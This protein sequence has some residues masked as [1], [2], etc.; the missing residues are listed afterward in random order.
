[1]LNAT[2]A[3]KTTTIAASSGADVVKPSRFRPVAF[4]VVILTVGGPVAACGGPEE[5]PGAD[6][7]EADS[8]TDEAIDV[9]TTPLVELTEEPGSPVEIDEPLLGRRRLSL[10]RSLGGE[11]SFGQIT[12]IRQLDSLLFVT[13]YRLP[14]HLKVME[15]GSGRVIGGYGRAGEGPGEFR[16]ATAVFVRSRDPPT[17][18][19][20]DYR[21]RRVSYVRFAGPDPRPELVDE[22]SL[23]YDEIGL[24][25]LAPYD[26]RFVAGGL[27]AD[28]SLAV[29]GRNGRIQERLV[30]EPPFG[31]EDIG[32]SRGFAALMNNVHFA[33]DG[34]GRVALAYEEESVVDLVDPDSRS[35][36]RVLGP[37]PVE[38]RYDVRD[39]RLHTGDENERAFR[40]VAA[41]DRLVFAG[42]LGGRVQDMPYGDRPHRVLVF[43]WRGRYLAELDL[44]RGITALGVSRDGARLWAGYQDPHP[45]IGEWTVPAPIRRAADAGGDAAGVDVR[46]DLSDAEAC[47]DRDR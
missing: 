15:M 17:V 4:A 14:P 35:Y 42:F 28:F 6:E 22:V 40:F 38:T 18:G 21:N 2:P 41:T 23:V 31:P 43:D 33:S 26:G 1:M 11:E 37:E 7:S 27:F 45:R 44:G 9:S 19:V 25:G 29:V 39:G 30:T 36:R 5:H 13:D 24:L 12:R 20:F 3:V 32:G 34:A 16:T 46:A 10:Q 47:E 8:T